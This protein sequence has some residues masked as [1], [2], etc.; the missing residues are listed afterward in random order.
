[1]APDLPVLYAGIISTGAASIWMIASANTLVQLRTAE[2]LRGRVM[3][4]WTMA[5]PGTLPITA[6]V[7]GA[8]AD[9]FGPRVAYAGAGVVIAGVAILFWR[10]YQEPV[11]GG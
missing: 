9:A 3:G 7:A 2:R 4:A 10:S 11:S 6:L 1:V 8:V 5:L